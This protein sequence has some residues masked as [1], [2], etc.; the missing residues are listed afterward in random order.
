MQQGVSY[1]LE[2]STPAQ[3]QS[4]VIVMSKKVGAAVAVAVA[5]AVLVHVVRVGT[6]YTATPRRSQPPG[7]LHANSHSPHAVHT[8]TAIAQKVTA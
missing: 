4:A 7:P 2:A 5:V 6:V 8:L 3:C 1:M